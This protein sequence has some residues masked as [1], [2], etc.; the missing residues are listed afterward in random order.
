MLRPANSRTLQLVQSLSS[1]ACAPG[2]DT[3]SKALRW[4][5]ARG[6]PMPVRRSFIELFDAHGDRR[7]PGA[8]IHYREIDPK[9][10]RGAA[11]SSFRNHLFDWP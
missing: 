3:N 5:V 8:S 6:Y 10:R 1:P 2:Q 11:H 4:R 7:M 9:E